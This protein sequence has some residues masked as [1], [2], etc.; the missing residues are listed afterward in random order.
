MYEYR[1]SVQVHTTSYMNRLY[2]TSSTAVNRKYFEY[3]GMELRNPGSFLLTIK[4]C[5]VGNGAQMVQKDK[6]RRNKNTKLQGDGISNPVDLLYIIDN[7]DQPADGEEIIG[8]TAPDGFQLQISPPPALDVS[9]VNRGVLV[10]LGLGW[11]GWAI[12]RKA[13]KKPN[14]LEYG[15]RVILDVDQS[16]HSM[17]LPLNA[18]YSTEN[19]VVGAWVVLERSTVPSRVSRSGRALT[20]NVRH[21]ELS[22]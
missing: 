17:K 4:K 3:R 20:P 10:R 13:Q 9:L 6:K 8:K 18:S 11:F 5:G 22:A 7:D 2:T 14:R 19:S 1:L 12:T 21:K 15:Y 16:T